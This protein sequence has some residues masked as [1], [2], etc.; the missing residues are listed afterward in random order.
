V[1]IPDSWVV[2]SYAA[3]CRGQQPLHPTGI[4]FPGVLGDLPARAR[5]DR[6]QQRLDEQP[7]PPS[8]LHPRERRRHQP[9]HRLE[10]RRPPGR[11]YSGSHGRRNLIFVHNRHD[12]AAAAPISLGAQRVHRPVIID[13]AVRSRSSATVL[14]R[15]HH[16]YRT[17]DLTDWRPFATSAS[18][19]DRDRFRAEFQRRLLP[20][21]HD[22]AN[23]DLQLF[24]IVRHSSI[25]QWHNPVP[26]TYPPT[27]ARAQGADQ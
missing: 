10:L 23:T 11:V 25:D 15:G 14:S 9:E 27:P 12:R 6:R 24:A 4:G 26:E 7:S 16:P 21:Y 22:L 2:G 5:L 1:K 17:A 3:S 19:A 8:G 18:A 20:T 13:Q